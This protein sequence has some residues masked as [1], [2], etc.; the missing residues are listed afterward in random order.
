VEAVKVERAM[1]N[2]DLPMLKIETDYTM[3]DSEQIKTRVEAFLEII[4]GKKQ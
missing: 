2:A 1:K 3:G 4:N